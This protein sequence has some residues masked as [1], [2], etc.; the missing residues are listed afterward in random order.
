[1]N[2]NDEKS[3]E[4]LADDMSFNNEKYTAEEI[5]KAIY[6]RERR[7]YFNKQWRARNED[8]VKAYQAAYN[9]KKNA[10][11]ADIIKYA[12]EKGLM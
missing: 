4:Q 8:K 5:E 2:T 12:K 7:K 1:M 11:E 9:K 3:F 10:K 6:N